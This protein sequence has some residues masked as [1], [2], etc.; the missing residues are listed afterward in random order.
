M[1]QVSVEVL[2]EKSPSFSF[3][4]ILKKR[5]K[6]K[7]KKFIN[8]RERRNSQKNVG[9]KLQEPILLK[10]STGIPSKWALAQEKLTQGG[11]VQKTDGHSYQRKSIK[12]ATSL[13]QSNAGGS[14]RGIDGSSL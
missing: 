10:G 12:F 1:L 5:K 4:R 14:F 8:R 7:E 3:R 6:R 11:V 2:D 13:N 9:G